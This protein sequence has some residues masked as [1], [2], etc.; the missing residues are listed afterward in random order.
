AAELLQEL[1]EARRGEGVILLVVCLPRA[2]QD[3][4][5]LLV[6]RLCPHRRAWDQAEAGTEK[7]EGERAGGAAR[8]RK[9]ADHEAISGDGGSTAGDRLRG[10]SRS[11]SIAANR[12]GGW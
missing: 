2:R 7:G 6:G 12:A 3:H 10:D 11:Q 5:R 1:A 9:A 4:L 8:G